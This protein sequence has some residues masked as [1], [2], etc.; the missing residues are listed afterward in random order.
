M[1]SSAGRSSASQTN[2]RSAASSR[3]GAAHSSSAPEEKPTGTMMQRSSV[4][5]G[6]SRNKGSRGMPAQITEKNPIGVDP[7]QG[8]GP[9]LAWTSLRSEL[10]MRRL[11]YARPVTRAT[12]VY[13]SPL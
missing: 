11:R 2:V 8:I 13:S 10:G 9:V 12:A 1:A 7:G 5:K 4:G 6:T 3:C